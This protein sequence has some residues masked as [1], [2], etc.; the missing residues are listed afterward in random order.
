LAFWADL[1]D[2]VVG[3]PSILSA[4]FANLADEVRRAQAGGAELIH[5]D[6]MDNHFVP[7][8]TIGPVVAAS[9]VEA[10]DL[11]VDAHL[12][13]D[14][15][16]NLIQPFVEAGVAS[17]S[18]QPEAVTHLHRTL[19]LIR[20][21]GCEAGAALNPTTPPELIEWALPYLDYVLV[22]S[23]NPGF[24]GQKFIPEMV[25]KV[26]RVKEM[27]DLPVQVDGGITAETAPLMVEAGAQVLVAGSAV[28]KGDPATEMRRIIEAGRRAL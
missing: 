10:V 12:M 24:G 23:V 20:G 9:L 6:A 17:I 19:E 27:T 22:M 5:F 7:N 21:G 16:D 18:V 26:R 4:D 13:V 14:N 8:L 15:P 25:E 28:Y 11:P 2:S 1:G 3:A